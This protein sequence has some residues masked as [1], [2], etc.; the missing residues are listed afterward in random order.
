M[1]LSEIIR[2][3]ILIGRRDGFVTFDQLNEL[4]PTAT[5]EPEDIE[6]VLLALSEE[7][8]SVMDND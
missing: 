7:K 3:A 6:A 4:L 5:T 1:K 2:A 8:I